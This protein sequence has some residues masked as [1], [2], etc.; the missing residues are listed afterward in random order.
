[1][2]MWLVSTFFVAGFFGWACLEGGA[3]NKGYTC[4]AYRAASAVL[5]IASL[6]S[7][8]LL[9]YKVAAA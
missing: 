6:T 7:L 4:W 5:S 1:M 9:I 3:Q 8:G 2:H